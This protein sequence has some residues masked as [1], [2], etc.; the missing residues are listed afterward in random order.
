V[1]PLAGPTGTPSPTVTGAPTG[2]IAFVLDDTYGF[3]D[4]VD[5]NIRN[6]GDRAYE[7]NSTGYEACNLVYR[8]ERGREFLI[9]P[10]T[11]CDTVQIKQIGPGQSVTLF[12]W[13]LNECVK[14]RFGCVE[15]EPLKPGTYK[16]EGTFKAANGGSPARA[17][18]TFE[19]VPIE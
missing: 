2:D 12:Q 8:D 18:A 14:D 9:P 19:I 17:E 16:I 4:K 15:S 5:V 10:G 11:H 3:M 13:H 6:N 1:G 7:Y